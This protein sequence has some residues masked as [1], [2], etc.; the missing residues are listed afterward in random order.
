MD[1]HKKYNKSS[2]TKAKKQELLNHL[3]ALMQKEKIYKQHGL[4]LNLLASLLNT[5]RTYISQV[6]NEFHKM[7]FNNF[8]NELRVAEAQNLLT[9]SKHKNMTYEGI[10]H[11]S[12]FKSRSAFNEAFKKI[13]GMTPSEY[14]DKIIQKTG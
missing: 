8:I 4:T 14:L 3:E 5:N 1:K 11:E 2:L 6:I 13:T 7:T 12:G 9:D 10:A